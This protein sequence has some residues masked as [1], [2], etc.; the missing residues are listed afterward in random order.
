L[1]TPLKIKQIMSVAEIEK[2]LREEAT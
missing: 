1:S 2:F